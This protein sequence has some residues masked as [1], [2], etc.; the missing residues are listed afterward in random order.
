M[1]VMTLRMQQGNYPRPSYGAP[2]QKRF[3]NANGGANN[4]VSSVS[5]GNHANC[6]QLCRLPPVRII[7]VLLVIHNPD[8]VN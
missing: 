4:R 2:P 6:P 3:R 8:E 1:F 7:V 5:H